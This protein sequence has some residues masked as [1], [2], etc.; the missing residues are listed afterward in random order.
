M[1][2]LT[3]SVLAGTFLFLLDLFYLGGIWTATSWGPIY[4]RSLAFYALVTGRLL[5]AFNFKDL[6]RSVF[7]AEVPANHFLTGAVLLSWLLT[8][9]LVTLSGP[10]KF[11]GLATLQPTHLLGITLAMPFLILLPAELFK[12]FG[13]KI[14]SSS[15]IHRGTEIEQ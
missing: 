4:A 6:Q 8:L 15:E 3:G 9:G 13:P 7:S 5:N 11:F 14:E 2:A 1:V 12:R 10:A